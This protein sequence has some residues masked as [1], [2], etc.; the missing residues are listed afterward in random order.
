MEAPCAEGEPWPPGS[1]GPRG[2][3]GTDGGAGFLRFLSYGFSRAFFRSRA[4]L[5]PFWRTVWIASL[6]GVIL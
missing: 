2:S 5:R 1:A 6:K 3:K 4:V